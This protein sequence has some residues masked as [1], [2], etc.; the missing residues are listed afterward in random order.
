MRIFTL[1]TCIIALL[2]LGTSASAQSSFERCQQLKQ[3]VSDMKQQAGDLS[4]QLRT[5]DTQLADLN[6]QI[7][8]LEASKRAKDRQLTGLEKQIR[9]NEVELKRRCRGMQNCERLEQQVENLKRQMEPQ[10]N[11]L[12]AIRD[13]IRSRNA[14]I[15]TLN[16]DVQRIETAFD[17]LGCDNL[18]IGQTAQSTFDRCGQLS[19]DWND[20]QNRIGAL[21]NS[22]DR[23]R[24][25]YQQ[26][27]KQM[28]ANST[29]LAR[30]LKEFRKSCSQSNRLAELETLEKEQHDYRAIQTDIDAMDTQ[31][32]KFKAMKLRPARSTTDQKP[33]LK[34]QDDKKDKKHKLRPVR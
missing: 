24:T 17:Q 10:S 13:E 7:R 26:I 6:R 8:D 12:R 33:T 31:V 22:V 28:Q 3:N 11:R 23:M 20:V 21:Q 18:Q 1:T 30:L 16:R 4:T 19:R 15:V 29:Q 34:P 32:R 27:M 25:A 14:E 9:A 2:G 5:I